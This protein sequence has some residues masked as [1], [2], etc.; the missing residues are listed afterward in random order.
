M[1][2]QEGLCN[3]PVLSETSLRKLS[4]GEGTPRCFTLKALFTTFLSVCFLS[5]KEANWETKK[6]VFTPKSPF[7]PEKIKIYNCRY[8]NFMCHQMPKH[9]K[10]AHFT[11]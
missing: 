10:E 9:K 3:I 2:K 1:S 8:S 11:E 5:L 4:E 6:N 7:V